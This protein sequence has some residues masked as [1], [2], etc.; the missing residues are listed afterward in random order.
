MAKV[1]VL[2]HSF[3][4]GDVDDVELYAA[5]PL[6]EW[7]QT[8][9]GKWVMQHAED[10]TYSVSADPYN[11]GYRIA[12]HGLLLEKD[13]TYFALKWGQNVASG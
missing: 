11:F 12:V 10:P 3:R 1:K 9:H 7:Q 5:Q 2:L 8:E 13:Y 6:W 4:M